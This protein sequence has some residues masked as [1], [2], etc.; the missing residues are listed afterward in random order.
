[1]KSRR[2]PK[3]SR[4]RLPREA[5]TE[6]PGRTDG[7]RGREVERQEVRGARCEVGCGRD[8]QRR[9]HERATS[10]SYSSCPSPLSS[11]FR[12]QR[13]VLLPGAPIKHDE[14]RPNEVVLAGCCRTAARCDWPHNPPKRVDKQQDGA[15]T[16]PPSSDPASSSGPHTGA[17]TC[18]GRWGSLKHP[19][20]IAWRPNNT[21]H[22]HLH[23]LDHLHGL[24]PPSQAA[25]CGQP[26]GTT[27]SEREAGD[28]RACPR[29]SNKTNDTS[30][31]FHPTC[32]V[33]ES[34][35]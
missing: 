24:H 27:L 35:T 15:A 13:A 28:A 33:G 17:C 19:K 9:G 20:P 31:T 3:T 6:E 16:S 14:S 10:L 11:L 34:L 26:R 12:Q 29:H 21:E 22:H 30:L 2:S 18:A 8:G 32:P 4:G 25:P 23:H 5:M 7:R 1:M